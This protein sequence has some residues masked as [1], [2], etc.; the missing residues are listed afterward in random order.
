METTE[1]PSIGERYRRAINS[2]DLRVRERIQGDSDILMAAGWTSG[3]GTML[4]RLGG[5][6]DEVKGDILKTAANDQ[7]GLL[8]IMM[9]LKTLRETR[10]ALTR[11]AWEMATKRG[12]FLDDRAVA[13]LASRGL[14]AWLEPNCRTCTGRGK[15]GGYDGQPQTTCRACGGTGEARRALGQSDLERAFCSLLLSEMDRMC[16]VA[17]GRLQRLL[18]RK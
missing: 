12:L 2:S 4:Y 17:G 6:F 5:E 3:L 9:H 13:S 8:L 10:E 15:M 18:S 16:H 11:F 14:V 7:T 1:K